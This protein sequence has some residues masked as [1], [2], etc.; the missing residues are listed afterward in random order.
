[1][2]EAE[3]EDRSSMSLSGEL[4]PICSMGKKLKGTVSRDF[5]LLVFEKL[6]ETGPL[7]YTQGLG[8]N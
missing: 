6:F 7:W 2:E 1:V 5:L 3:V 4:S 8:G